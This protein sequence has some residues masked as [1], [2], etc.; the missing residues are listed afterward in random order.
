MRIVF[1]QNMISP[2]QAPLIRELSEIQGIEVWWVVSEEI[3]KHREELGW[4]IP[5][6]GGGEL[7]VAPNNSEIREIALSKPQ[8]SVHILAGLTAYECCRKAMEVLA[9]Q[10]LA[11][12][13]IQAEAPEFLGVKGRFRT[14]REK[15]YRRKFDGSVDF[16]LALGE[17]AEIWYRKVGYKERNIF[18]FGYFVEIRNE[19][20]H[21]RPRKN[22]STCRKLTFVGQ[23]IP[24]KGVDT[25]LFAYGNIQEK[26]CALQIIGDG[27][28]RAYYEKLSELLG[29]DDRVDFTGALARPDALKAIDG[30]DALV[31]PSRWDGWGAVTNE[32]LM[33]GVPVLLTEQCG[34]RCVINEG[35]SGYVVRPEDPAGLATKMREILRGELSWNEQRIRKTYAELSAANAAKYVCK[36]ID[37]ARHSRS[38]P[39][40]TWPHYPKV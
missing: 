8:N 36:V 5:Q 10:K 17:L 40:P 24:R 29:V 19:S 14:F 13:G 25:L 21:S 38:Q 23:L 34:S 37:S 4:A 27:P 33:Q 26:A 39:E 18:P 31:L 9:A 6:A 22:Q 7:V 35:R 3:P 16:V 2:H 12:I 30:S 20:K 32:A 15:W 11:T 28:H 1:W